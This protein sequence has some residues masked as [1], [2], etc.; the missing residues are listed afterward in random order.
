MLVI[1][2]LNRFRVKISYKL[3]IVIFGL[4][5]IFTILGYI[6]L[7]LLFPKFY[8][9]VQTK[10]LKKYENEIV[11]AAKTNNDNRLK[12]AI[13]KFLIETEVTPIIFDENNNIFYIPDINNSNDIQMN[14]QINSSSLNMSTVTRTSSATVVIEFSFK[15]KTYSL[16]YTP[17][18]RTIKDTT[19]VLIKFSIY[20]LFFSILLS[21]LIAFLFSKQIVI[22]L[23]K[24]NSIAKNMVNLDFNHQVIIN[25]DDEL[26]ELANSLN[27]LGLSLQKT[28]KELEDKNNLL[29]SELERERELDQLR[30]EF[31][32]AISH[33]L[34]TPLASAMGIIEAM[35]YEIKPYDDHKK[36]LKKT[37]TILDNM[38]QLIQE[39]LSISKLEKNSEVLLTENIDLNEQ[40]RNITLN[41]EKNPNFR[42]KKI[43]WQTD[44]K[45]VVNTNLKMLQKVLQNILSNAF[46]YT[47]KNG[48][49]KITTKST[50]NGVY[51][52]IFNTSPPISEKELSKLFEPF[53]R[54]EKSGN[55]STGGT[56]VGLF[57]TKQ[58]LT[59]LTVSYHIKNVNN[60]I[61]FELWF[62]N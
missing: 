44:H 18:I 41:L 34:K 45:I 25:S 22:P 49:I 60:G 52:S 39:M 31:I 54:L 58:F 1:K 29:T 2:L 40:L 50:K 14:G 62:K 55:K 30:N 16:N 11:V 15:G 56:G 36:Y 48:K 8:Y 28:M 53:Y 42:T 12:K 21:I 46:L 59:K 33:E 43:S 5:L 23:K 27:Y 26:G 17:N 51:C 4:L 32:M 6:I 7:I 3:F 57:I 37:Y 24:M 61:L 38:A 47:T 19:Q 13:D 9:D 35:E 20:F 10:N